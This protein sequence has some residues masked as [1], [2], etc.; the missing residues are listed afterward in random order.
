MKRDRTYVIDI[1]TNDLL[2]NMLDYTSFPYKLRKDAKLWCVVIRDIATG[3]IKEAVKEDITYEW[4]KDS[5][6]DCKTLIAHNGIKFDFI[7]LKLFGVLDYHVGYVGEKSTLFGQNCTLIDT[8]IVSR[9]TNPDRFKGHSLGAWGEKLGNAKDDFRQQCI[10][11]GLIEKDA[12]KGA[13]FKQWTPIMLEYCRQDTK[14]NADVFYKLLEEVGDF[15]WGESIRMENKLADLG[16]RRESLGFDFDKDLAIECL[17]D[18]TQKMQELTDKVNPLLPERDMNKSELSYYTPPKI[19]IKKNGELSSHMINFID[20]LELQY[21]DEEEEKFI[22]FEGKKYKLPHNEPLKSKV[23]GTIDDMNH[24]KMFLIEL[25]WVPSEWRVRDLTKDSKK[26]SLPYKKRIVAL[27]RWYEE[28]MAGKFKE[29]RLEELDIHP[30]QIIDI[31]SEKLEGDY[32]VRVPTSPPIRVGVQKDLCP[33]L[34]KLG[35]KVSFAEDFSL[36]LTYKHRKSSIAG[37][38]VEDMDFDEEYPN[39]GFL[40]MYREEDGRI[41]TP[42]IELGAASGRFVHIGVCNIARPSS[43]YGKEMRSLFGCGKGFIQLGYDFSSL[44]NRIQGNYVYKYKG[45]KDLAKMLIA[46]KPNDLHSVNAKKLGISRSEAKSITYG[47]LYGAQPEKIS[48]M[49]SVSLKEAKKIYNGF[50]D[51][52]PALRDLKT[53]LE[54]FWVS[55]DKKFIL[56]IDGRKIMVRSQHSLLN[57]LLQ[58]GGVICAKYTAVFL[59][60]KLEE[61]GYCIDCFKGKPDVGEMISYH[62]EQQLAVNPKLIDIK[63]FE[64]EEEAKNFVENFKGEYKLSSLKKEKKWY[65]ALP[66][67]LSKSIEDSVD[68][69]NSFLNLNVPLGIEYDVHKNWFG[70]H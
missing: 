62:D 42:A 26:Q 3:E 60:Q 49:L 5:L 12:P 55:T 43:V 7:T 17:E 30:D 47:I 20:R 13:Q 34:V 65:V 35:E 57:F 52:V 21:F 51:A 4:M 38:D 45:G 46:E 36:Y 58:S 64:S 54:E 23:P 15:N 31:L 63:T 32:P 16:V 29:A 25:G 33:H 9:I 28:T 41:P 40:S 56:G 66:S 27:E 39:S 24:I 2:A 50:W 69:T 59:F 68:L 70:C 6:K 8:L 61:K 14:V 22:E 18:L 48:K 44:E 1:E 11:A 19:Q 10:D 53:K 37:G 67:E